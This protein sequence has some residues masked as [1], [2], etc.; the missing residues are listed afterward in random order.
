MRSVQHL[1]AWVWLDGKD[2]LAAW[3]GDGEN[4]RYYGK[5]ILQKV[6]EVYGFDWRE[7]DDD[8]WTESELE[9]GLQADT[10]LKLI[11]ES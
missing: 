3:I 2:E 4:Y 8:N 1:Y 10:V 9:T 6:S 5:P 11:A 7:H